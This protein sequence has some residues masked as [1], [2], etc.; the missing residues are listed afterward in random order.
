MRYLLCSLDS[1]GFLY[2]MVGIAQ[3]L[4]RRG[5]TVACVT[6]QSR[7]TLLQ[8]AGVERIPRTEADGF[9][10]Q[11]VRWWHELEIALQVRHLDYA[12][13]TFRPDV[14]VGQALALGPL[15]A[16]EQHGLPLA[17]LG[18]MTY[19]WPTSGAAPRS[20]AEERRLIR[21]QDMLGYYNQARAFFELPACAPPPE[22]SPF[23]ADLLLLQSV[24]AATPAHA[25]LPERVRLV[26]SCGWEPAAQDAALGAWLARAAERGGPILYAQPGRSFRA[27]TFWGALAA[28]LAGQPCW[29]AASLDRMP[30]KADQIP[31]AFFAGPHVPQGQV[32]PHAQ[33]VISNG[34][35]T[36]ALGALTHGLPALVLPGGGEQPDVAELCQE[37]GAALVLPAEAASPERLSALVAELLRRDDLR[38]AA[39][40]LRAAFQQVDGPSA[41]AG[42]IETLRG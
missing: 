16:A 26:G 7:Q 41:A 3:E 35:T 25:E 4:Q 29:V 6:D 10:F 15:I 23:L 2:P 27:P 37:L 22:Q 11:V 12:I 24:P 38:R 9:S 13:A 28:G 17:S 21:Y 34:N 5:H 31:A 36:A 20:A 14:L 40:A 1:L 30:G 42:W 32:L 18:L 33:A 39:E 19:L 8:R